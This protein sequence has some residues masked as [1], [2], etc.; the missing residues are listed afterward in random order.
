MRRLMT[1][2]IV[3]GLV[4]T[5]SP[6]FAKISKSQAEELQG[7]VAK[8][9]ETTDVEAKH[10]LLLVRG[11]TADA[12]ER[13]ALIALESDEDARTRLGAKLA[14]ILAG[15]KKAH[16]RVAEELI[17]QGADFGLIRWALAPLEDADELQ[18]LRAIVKDGESA[19]VS[20]VFQYLGLARGI[21]FEELLTALSSSDA[22]RRSL[23]A[24]QVVSNGRADALPTVAKLA[25]AKDENVRHEALQIAVAFTKRPD[26]LADAKKI[27]VS[28][29]SDASP[30]NRELAARRLVELKDSA[31]VSTLLNVARAAAKPAAVASTLGFLVEHNVKPGAAAVAEWLESDDATVKMRAFQL[32]AMDD[33]KKFVDTLLEMHGSTEFEERLLAVQSIGYTKDP[34]ASN[35]L[36]TSLFEARQD[37]RGA[38]VDGLVQLARADTLDALKKSFTQERDKAIKLR[39]ID[40]IGAVGGAQALQHLRFQV[41]NSDVDIKRHT[42]EAIRTI[43]LAEGAKALD[44]LLRDRNT[45][46][47]WRAFLAML[48]LDAN[49]ARAHFT[50]MFRNPPSTFMSDV[51]ALDDARQKIVLE[52]LLKDG[53]GTARDGAIDVAKRRGSHDSTLY[54]IAMSS[55]ADSRTRRDLVQF[56]G[57]RARAKDVTV[58][59]TLARGKDPSIARLAAWMLTRHPSKSLEASYRGYLAS[60]DT[61]LRAIAAY[62]L[63]TVWR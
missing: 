35:V 28:A 6:A 31:G 52:Y 40:A 13:K 50:Q 14:A 5:A 26:T 57:D 21:L 9:S 38:A 49:A 17:K 3:V 54:E 41:T 11:A 30:R 12:A 44:M 8:L 39:V 19:H 46:V 20:A 36:T 18:V 10:A 45:E 51:A 7:Y 56:F 23:A 53:S 29:A 42:V 24:K 43:G 62:G 2:A 25:T 16:G 22:E 1:V 15:D 37:I 48:A 58:L 63:A 4:A 59:E 33:D 32:T 55:T 27:L 34:R 61:N 60:K 47:Q